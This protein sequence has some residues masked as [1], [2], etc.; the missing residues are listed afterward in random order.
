[1]NSVNIIRLALLFHS[2]IQLTQVDW[3]CHNHQLV[4]MCILITVVVT[5]VFIILSVITCAETINYFPHN[6]TAQGYS[7]LNSSLISPTTC[8]RCHTRDGLHIRDLYL[9]VGSPSSFVQIFG[10]VSTDGF[11]L[12]RGLF[13]VQT[14]TIGI[15]L[16]RSLWIQCLRHSDPSFAPAIR[17]TL[18]SKL[19][20]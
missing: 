19:I 2:A 20:S 11:L 6:D 4:M 14:D 12:E 18:P 16:N 1:M 7:A 3:G 9:R 5:N 10:N 13:E 8:I 15:G 17:V